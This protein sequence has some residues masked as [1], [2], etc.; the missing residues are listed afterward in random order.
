MTKHKQSNPKSKIALLAGAGALMAFM[1]HVYADN[2]VDDLL[3]KL[4]KKG[5]LTADEADQLKAENDAGQTN[6]VTQAQPS[7]WK[8]SNTFKSINL[9]GDFRLRYEYRGVD[10]VP[11]ASPNT[12]YRERFR[13]ALRFGIRG[14]LV[15]D[16]YY[17]LRLETSTNPR[18]PWATFGN[19]TTAGSVTP[20]DK[21]QSGINIG[22][23]FI[24][25]HPQSWFDITAGR[26]AMPLY[27][28]PMVL[29][30]GYQSRRRL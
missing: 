8:I 29:G 11:G 9:Y 12:F 3:N 23:A 28:T 30:F 10:N 18:S 16:F 6:T 15:D 27:T 2:S 19:N 22:Q 1:P 14:D 25:W 4:E 20:S 21:A 5:V 26:M 24:G 7:V 17:G 13:Y